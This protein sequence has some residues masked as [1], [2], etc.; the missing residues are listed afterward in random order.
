MFQIFTAEARRRYFRQCVPLY[1]AALKGDWRAAKDIII[2]D[3]TIICA[4]ITKGWQTALHVA[5]GARHV[6]FVEE[7]VKLL[8]KED[9]VLQDQKGN[10]A[11]CFAAAAGTVQVAKIMIQKNPTLPV[12]RGGEGMTALYFATLFGHGEMAA[13]LYP[14]IIQI[15]E[16]GERAGIFFTCI[17]TDLY[18]N[19]VKIYMFS[20]VL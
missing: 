13:Y 12:I 3:D 5:A 19:H 20:H 16:E 14:K 17:N 4:C 8:D 18:G 11:F 1:K 7:L 15:I 2:R 9:L 6:E 10:T